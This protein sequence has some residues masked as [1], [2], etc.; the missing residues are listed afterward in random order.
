MK[1]D[2][3]SLNPQQREA[4]T[5]TGGPLLVLSGPGSGK[6]RV[7]AYRIAYLVSQ[8]VDP[9]RIL[10]L[11][12]TNKAAKEMRER[13]SL[14]LSSDSREDQTLPRY[15]TMGTFHSVSARI[16][17]VVGKNAGIPPNFIIYDHHDLLTLVKR[18]W[19]SLGIDQAGLTPGY[20]LEKI[21]RAKSRL[22]SPDQY[23][24][25]AQSGW[26][27]IVGQV[28]RHYEEELEKARA[29]DFDDL[30]MKTVA[31]F[32]GHP[33]ILAQWQKKFHHIL[34]D[35]FQ[36]TDLGQARL[37][38]L[39]AKTHS[40]ICAVGDDAQ[41]IYGF[42]AADFR[43]ILTFHTS[44][45]GAKV[46][47]LEQNYRSTKVILQAA[48]SLISHNLKRA[49]KDLW[50]ANE[51]GTTIRVFRGRDEQDEADYI[52]RSVTAL[53]IPL[54]EA[55]VLF[56]VNA[57]SRPIEE[58]FIRKGIP[59][60]T[61]GLIRFYDRKEIKDILAYLRIFENPA[62]TVSFARIINVPRRGIGKE[63]IRR[64]TPYQERLLSLCEIPDELA[65]KLDKRGLAN[66]KRFLSLY[67]S[68]KEELS[69]RP[70]SG[71]I[72]FLLGRLEYRKTFEKSEERE[73]RENVLQEFIGIAGQFEG[74]GDETLRDFLER[75]MLYSEEHRE[76]GN[77][78]T[79]TT[80]HA[81]K[82]LEFSAVCITGFEYGIFPHYKSLL[83]EDALEEERRLC[84]VALTRA[85]K[86]LFLTYAR[87][88]TLYGRTQANPPSNFL[89]EIPEELLERENSREFGI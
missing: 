54:S 62:D 64:I 38:T 10:A 84:Y 67:A 30:I 1:L 69:R 63:S 48:S 33:A 7:L 72:E 68:A 57:Q 43:N 9:N 88:R 16:L 46:V 32:E 87:R 75:A 18:I 37:I 5:F 11:T 15:L 60:R 52:A 66:L 73:E 28:Y 42:R 19:N 41:G 82:G 55:A 40:N 89:E 86:Y 34:V 12:F 24:S 70:L 49:H 17:R 53:S 26:H 3:S 29:F 20:L 74:N 2:L 8:G 6:T 45:P 56:R 65:E 59:Y 47:K 27:H 83:D 79:L 4:V 21:S 13:V 14:L 78:V 36:D 76:E 81:A 50:T 58:A 85:K 31:V 39:L 23:I 44:W 51:K 35:E 25:E 71:F 80:M 77:G 22:V 61:V